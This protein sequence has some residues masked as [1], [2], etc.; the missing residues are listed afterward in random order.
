LG[1]GSLQP[2]I[3]KAGSIDW[4][5]QEVNATLHTMFFTELTMIQKRREKGLMTTCM[6]HECVW[7]GDLGLGLKE[8]LSK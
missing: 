3:L 1:L 2:R 4:P 6:K 8:R 5:H 7:A